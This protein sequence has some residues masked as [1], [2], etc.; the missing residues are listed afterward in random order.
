MKQFFI[1]HKTEKKTEKDLHHIWTKW[2]P[3][4]LIHITTYAYIK[5][6]DKLIKK[7]LNILV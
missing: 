1:C 5:F 4:S 7:W 2:C 6:S 3:F